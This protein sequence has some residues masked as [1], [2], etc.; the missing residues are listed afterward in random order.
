MGR[1]FSEPARASRGRCRLCGD[2]TLL[3]KTHVPARS[4]GNVGTARAPIEVVDGEGQRRYGLGRE[5][6]GGMWGRWFCGQ[7]NNATRRWD[8]EYVRWLPEIFASLHDPANSGNRLAARALDADPG[9]FVRCLWAWMFAISDN[10]LDRFPAI[11]ASVRSGQ[12]VAPPVDARLLLAATRDL[13]FG[14]QALSFTI[15]VTAPP[16]V[17]LHVAQPAFAHV[18]CGFF[19]T[20]LWLLEPAG[21]RCDVEFELPIVHTFDEDDLPPVGEFVI[22]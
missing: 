10:F 18:P 19:N 12:S 17:A 6:L 5:T 2:V 7:C 8:E 11:A 13:Q 4:A 22:D 3:T 1:A 9:A 20:G 16:F 21:T 14:I 15:G